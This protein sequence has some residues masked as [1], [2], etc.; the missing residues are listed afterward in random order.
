[1]TTA[2]QTVAPFLLTRLQLAD[3]CNQRGLVRAVEV[4][5]D[6]GLFAEQFLDRWK[7]EILI[8]VDTW[9]PYGEM[10]YDRLPD[11][12]MA[13][14]LLA[15][16]RDRV[17]IARGES[18]DLAKPIGGHYRPGFVY[19]DSDHSYESVKADIRA[20]WPYL[21]PGGILAGHDYMHEH[22]GV[23]RAVD[24]FAASQ[25]LDLH[26]TDDLNEYRS[27]WIIKPGDP[28]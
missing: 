18:V 23:I 22:E 13:G 10:P 27:W 5:T 20:W 3:V 19:I 1:M 4:G 12:M 21:T 6:R 16:F 24:E 9:Q 2:V 28:A 7:G 14:M 25:C 11:L 15:R 26:V 8:C 17:K